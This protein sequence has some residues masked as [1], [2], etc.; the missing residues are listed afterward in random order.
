MIDGT[1]DTA[2]DGYDP[3]V[4]YYDQF[5]ENAALQHQ[6]YIGY[7]MYLQN[8]EDITYNRYSK[9]LAEKV[10]QQVLGMQ[11]HDIGDLLAQIDPDFDISGI[12]N[13]PDIAGSS[14][15]MTRYITDNATKKFL[16]VLNASTL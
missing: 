14:D 7:Q 12:S 9:E 11:N 3:Y 10:K 1:T 15:I 16:E 13:G 8:M 5:R 4:F 2:P 6:N